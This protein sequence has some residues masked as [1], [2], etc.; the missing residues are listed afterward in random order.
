[1]PPQT[2]KGI[3]GFLVPAASM[4][5]A[6][7]WRA[8]W[9]FALCSFPLLSFDCACGCQKRSPS[10]DLMTCAALAGALCTCTAT[11]RPISAFYS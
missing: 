3:A 8:G 9:L 4:L 10:A 11:R 7:R 1:L 2:R 6:T 5:L